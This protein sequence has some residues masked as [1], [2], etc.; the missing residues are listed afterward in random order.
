[1]DFGAAKLAQDIGFEQFDAVAGGETAGIPFAAFIA[2][3]EK[4]PTAYN[5]CP[6]PM[7]FI[8]VSNISSHLRDSTEFVREVIG[9]LDNVKTNWEPH[10]RTA[11][12]GFV[13][14]KKFNLFKISRRVVL[15]Y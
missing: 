13:T 3:S 15:L 7:D 11:R 14:D 5:F 4:K 9:E 2:E 1:M 6:S 10:G 12:K 8:H